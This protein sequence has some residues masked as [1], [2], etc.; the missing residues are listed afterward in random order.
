VLGGVGA[1]TIV[2]GHTHRQFDR[3]VGGR[4]FLN[5]GSVGRPYEGRPGAFWALLG[6]GVSL[7]RSDYDVERAVELLTPTGY[8]DLADV[9]RESL[10][11]PADPDQVSALFETLATSI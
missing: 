9:L 7:R 6:D 11:E 5:A 10:T 4:R 2:G 3:T 1:R 8:P